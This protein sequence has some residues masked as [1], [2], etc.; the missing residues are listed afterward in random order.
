MPLK[1]SELY[2]SL[3]KNCDE[4]RGD[5]DAARHKDYVLDLLF[6]KYVSDKAEC[7]PGS[8][9]KVPYGGFFRDMVLAKADKKI[10]DKLNKI[11][12][13][14]AEANDLTGV[15]DVADFNEADKLGRGK[16]M[17][18]RLTKLIGIVQAKNASQTIHGPTCGSGS[19]LLKSAAEA[20]TGVT[21]YGQERD[22]AIAALAE[23]NMILHNHETAKIW[24]DNTLSSPY[25]TQNDGSRNTFGYMVANPHFSG[26]ASSPWV[27]KFKGNSPRFIF[28]LLRH[29]GLERFSTGS[30]VPTLNRNDVHAFSVLI[31]SMATEQTAIATILS[32]MDVEITALEPHR[33]KT[34]A[35]QQGMTQE[36]LTGRIRLSI[37]GHSPV[38]DRTTPTVE[39]RQ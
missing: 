24:Q 25:W 26:K 23:M 11:V 7:D 21:I 22:N 35:L 32:D 3:W 4:L 19:L 6:A 37:A 36:L 15:I 38:L 39:M 29:I 10:G 2:A 14:L 8:L 20:K 33:D 1:K 34:H 30:G 16:E 9:P 17:V 12:R 13:R 5:M 18:G 31:P 28:Y 27:T